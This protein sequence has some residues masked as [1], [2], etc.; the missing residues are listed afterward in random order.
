[1]TYAVT[2][3]EHHDRVDGEPFTVTVEELEIFDSVKA[4]IDAS[5]QLDE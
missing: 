3:Q 2:A 5:Q 4:A 1:M